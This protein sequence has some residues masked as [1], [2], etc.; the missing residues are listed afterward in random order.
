M[1]KILTR[2]KKSIEKEVK[3]GKRIF[4]LAI[5][6]LFLT[7]GFNAFAAAPILSTSQ[8]STIRVE[9][10]YNPYGVIVSSTEVTTTVTHTT[11]VNGGWSETTTVTTTTSSW[12]GGSLKIDSVSGT[13]NTNAS[14]GSSSTTSFWTDYAYNANGQLSGAS[15]G[16][17]TE[18]NRGYDANGRPIGTFT[19][20]SFDSYV[21][22]NGQTLRSGSV[23]TGTNYGPDGTKISTFTET[24]EYEYAFIGGGWHLM[25]EVST[26]TTV[27]E[28]EYTT[29]T[30]ERI[31]NTETIT[32]VKTYQRNA[33]GFCIGISQTTTG[34][35]TEINEQGGISTYEMQNYQASAT[36]DSKIG[37]Y[38]SHDSYDWVES[39][40]SSR[41]AQIPTSDDP[42]IIGN[43]RAMRNELYMSVENIIDYNGSQSGEGRIVRLVAA[44]SQEAEFEALKQLA[45]DNGGTLNNFIIYGVYRGQGAENYTSREFVFQGVGYGPF[46]P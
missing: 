28:N 18:G 44:E 1:K 11:D 42:A 8:N 13:S 17:H 14:D 38:V 43:V 39:S 35:K 3:M 19:S 30:G 27:G 33:N 15:G 26:S 31:R 2:N 32:R 25:S 37:W 6:L 34:T 24:T 12:R 46:Q 21:I 16:A 7:G 40:I 9:N 20:D 22:R 45:V 4:V 29:P 23:T 10:F 5:G 36:Y 41:N